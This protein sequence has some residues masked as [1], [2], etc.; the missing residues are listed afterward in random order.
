MKKQSLIQKL[1][2]TIKAFSHH[3]PARLNKIIDTNEG[4]KLKAEL[5]QYMLLL[6]ETQKS[7]EIE[8]N[9]N[10]NDEAWHEIAMIAQEEQ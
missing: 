7:H 4:N 6:D 10:A 1:I 3:D 9:Y 2:T 5:F 8:I